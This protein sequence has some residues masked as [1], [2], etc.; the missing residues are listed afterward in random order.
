MIRTDNL[1][2]ERANIYRWFAYLLFQELS[3]TDIASLNS[4]ELQQL[5]RGL[6]SIPELR[7]PADL[8]RRKLKA[9]I[10]RPDNHLELAADYAEL[11][12]MAP[13]SGVSPYA[14]HY[15]HSS[16]AEER[17]RMNQWLSHLK[18]QT[19]NNEASDHLAVQ[20]AVLALLIESPDSQ[21]TSLFSQH[22]YIRDRLLSWL[23]G[24]VKL[25][26][27]RDKFGFYSSLLRLLK[28][29]ILQDEQYLTE[30]IQLSSSSMQTL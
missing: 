5:L 23:P 7:L 16:P 28:S 27:Q 29:Y 20:L 10:N 25:C 4:P 11:F 6:K 30:C 19:G 22:E 12:L 15:P 13:P 3:V 2:R 21:S 17:I 18:Q 24:M 14:G 26:L 1:A 9:L 8:F